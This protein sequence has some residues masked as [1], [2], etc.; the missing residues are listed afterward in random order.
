[1]EPRDYLSVG[2]NDSITDYLLCCRGGGC[3]ADVVDAFED[4]RVRYAGVREHVAVD[5]R[6]G[7]GAEAVVEEAVAAGGLVEEGERVCL[8]VVVK[9]GEEEVRPAVYSRS[10]VNFV[11][12]SGVIRGGGDTDYSHSY[13][14]PVHPLYCR[15]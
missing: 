8:G 14:S 5:A 12:I 2:H 11:Y 1:M 3:C 9:V 6:E 10:Y 7:V 4:D 13:R 15:R